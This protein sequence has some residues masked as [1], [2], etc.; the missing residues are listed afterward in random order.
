MQGWRSGPRGFPARKLLQGQ[1]E[2]EGWGGH[3]MPNFDFCLTANRGKKS[4][5]ERAS[6]PQAV[7][8]RNIV[9]SRYL[10]S[11]PGHR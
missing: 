8:R 5:R 11:A 1:R 2:E 6:N 4:K 7:P 10:R 9:K 3:K